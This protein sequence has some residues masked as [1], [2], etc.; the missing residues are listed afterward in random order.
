MND[1]IPT[2]SKK[3]EKNYLSYLKEPRPSETDHRSAKQAFVRRTPKGTILG[4]ANREKAEF[5]VK[6]AIR[7]WHWFA[8]IA[9]LVFGVFILIPLFITM[10]LIMSDGYGEVGFFFFGISA[11]IA[12][13][14]G[15]VLVVHNRFRPW[16]KVH[17]TPDTITYGDTSYDRKHTS[18][19]VLGYEVKGQGELKNHFFDQ[20]MGLMALRLTYGRW[21][22]D[23][24]YMVNKYHAAEIVIW[25]NEII[26][27]VGA[28]KPAEHDLEQGR[29]TEEF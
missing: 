22:E 15:L 18:G 29:K 4:T 24:P 20:S 16:V 21:G 3:N 6:S 26:A 7:F 14:I 10:F 19:F 12:A 11:G 8:P 2:A 17:V 1:D 25:M 23:L 28:P 9:A 27:A 5:Q 13:T